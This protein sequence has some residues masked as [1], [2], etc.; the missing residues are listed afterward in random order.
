MQKRVRLPDVNDDLVGL[1][2]RFS[3]R[4][5]VASE[6]WVEPEMDCLRQSHHQCLHNVND[7]KF[8]QQDFEG[9][10]ARKLRLYRE[11]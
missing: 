7:H 5:P 9:F 4:E 3:L 8:T 2:T 6:K 1:N 11:D 10:A